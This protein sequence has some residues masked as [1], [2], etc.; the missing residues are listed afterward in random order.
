MLDCNS[1]LEILYPCFNVP[2]ESMNRIRKNVALKRAHKR[3][4]GR[5]KTPR[6][7]QGFSARTCEKGFICSVLAGS[8]CGAGATRDW[9]RRV[10][11]AHRQGPGRF[12]PVSLRQDERK[13]PRERGGG[14]LTSAHSYTDNAMK[15]THAEGGQRENENPTKQEAPVKPRVGNSALLCGGVAYPGL[16]RRF[17]AR[18]RFLSEVLVCC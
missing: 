6:L 11:S 13:A 14:F 8:G 18:C 5:G 3:S 17:G 1:A 4:S 15:C 9:G 16:R 10:E 12:L 2:L 7:W